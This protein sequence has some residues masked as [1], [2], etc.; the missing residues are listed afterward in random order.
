MSG[1]G[2]YINNRGR[3]SSNLLES[4]SK[5]IRYTERSRVDKWNDNF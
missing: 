3:T 4:M 5:S 2:G 1:I